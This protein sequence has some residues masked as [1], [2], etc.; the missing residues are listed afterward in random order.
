MSPVKSSEGDV[1]WFKQCAVVLVPVM[2]MLAACSSDANEA[3]IDASIECAAASSWDFPDTALG[4]TSSVVI[5]VTGTAEGALAAPT[6]DGPD[7]AAFHV[8]LDASSCDNVGTLA[9]GDTCLTVVELTPSAAHAQHASLRIGPRTIA[10][11]GT[12]VATPSGLVASVGNVAAIH[13]IYDLSSSVTVRLTNEG[14]EIAMLGTEAVISDGMQVVLQSL[15][16]ASLAPGGAC[17]LTLVTSQAV[18]GCA[19]GRVS[20]PSTVNTVEIPVSSRYLGGVTITSFA[21]KGSGRVVS[22]PPGIDCAGVTGSGGEIV[23]TGRCE[24]AFE[25][26]V[27]LTAIPD[28]ASHFNGWS[29]PRCGTMNNCLVDPGVAPADGQRVVGVSAAFASPSAKAIDV[30]FAGAG[31]GFVGGTL[32]CAASCQ[33]WVEDGAAA[34]LTASTPSQFTGWSG[35]CS[36]TDTR[37]DLGLV[38]NDRAVTVTFGP[39]PGEVATL[40]PALEGRI[41]RGQI[42]GDGDLVVVHGPDAKQLLR[43]SRLESSGVVR[44]SRALNLSDVASLR[45]AATGEMYVAGS[46]TL[47]PTETRVV[48]LSVLGD[49]LWQTTVPRTQVLFYDD[50]STMAVGADGRV[51]VV[52]DETLRVFTAAGAPLWSAQ[53]ARPTA[54]AID[55]VGRVAVVSFEGVVSWFDASGGPL[56]QTWILPVARQLRAALRFDAADHLVVQT[57]SEDQVSGGPGERTLAEFDQA[58]TLVFSSA[59]EDPVTSVA[60][61]GPRSGGIEILPGHQVL[62]WIGHLFQSRFGTT[63]GGGAVVETYSATGEATLLVDKP[64]GIDTDDALVDGVVVSDMGCSPTGRC[65]L[66]GTFN[67]APAR[68]WIEV[69]QLP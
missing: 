44:W 46:S 25:E 69:L 43:V 23:P 10:L 68:P 27:T 19:T 67:V 38:V 58:G 4:Q 20:L 54:V 7:A 31:T 62:S 13:G 66:F 15:C 28:G 45:L 6:I 49:V 41:L 55:S 33:G 36:G 29:N 21:G 52:G 12:A 57:R 42:T 11:G 39:D 32:S 47:A 51:A 8:N 2:G 16:P 65:A 37:C 34:F 17:E 35:A 14:S 59:I 40:F 3:E 24:H 60:S 22:S 48:K 50:P 1:V 61:P 53:T 63:I 26:P 30:T 9:I 56:P 5:L 64:V 18:S